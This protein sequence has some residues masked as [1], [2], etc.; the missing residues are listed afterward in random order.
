MSNIGEVELLGMEF[1]AHHGCLQSEREQGNLFV[2][3]FYAQIDIRKAATSDELSDT[4]DYGQV[5]E[6]IS[7]QMSR[8]CNLLEAVAGRIVDSI[9]RHYPEFSFI[10]VKVSKQHPPVSG[11]CKWSAVS[12]NYGKR[13]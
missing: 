4:V 2:V 12:A 10:R 1:H 6:L 8:P 5:Y 7:E 9:A 3:D 11:S 13:V